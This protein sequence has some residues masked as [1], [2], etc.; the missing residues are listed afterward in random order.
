MLFGLARDIST[1]PLPL[2]LGDEFACRCHR[3]SIDGRASGLEVV[4]R[5]TPGPAGVEKLSVTP[6]NEHRPL[7]HHPTLRR[8][9]DGSR[10]GPFLHPSP[11]TVLASNVRNP[12]RPLSCGVRTAGFF[13]PLVA[14]TLLLFQFL[15]PVALIRFDLAR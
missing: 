2:E 12:E 5:A 14:T 15:D 8:P 3:T 4:R 10:A 11:I 9:C 7:D 13:A 1:S 6:P